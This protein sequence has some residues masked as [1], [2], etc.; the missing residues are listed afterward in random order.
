MS[1]KNIFLKNVIDIQDGLLENLFK[2]LEEGGVVETQMNRYIKLLK[3]WIIPRI[4]FSDDTGKGTVSIILSS[5]SLSRSQ[6]DTVTEVE[7]FKEKN[8]NK[9][10]IYKENR[11]DN[12]YELLMSAQETTKLTRAFF[13]YRIQNLNQVPKTLINQNFMLLK[14]IKQSLLTRCYLMKIIENQSLI[15]LAIVTRVIKD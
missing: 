6:G 12:S 10:V 1:S 13:S 11:N 4:Y 9:I 2:Q 3:I 5:F 15:I 7:D 14:I 8:S